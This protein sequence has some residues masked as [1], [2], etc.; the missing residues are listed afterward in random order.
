MGLPPGL[1][2]EDPDL[3]VGR[4]AVVVASGYF[5][6][7]CVDEVD[8]LERV[9]GTTITVNKFDWRISRVLRAADD[10]GTVLLLLTDPT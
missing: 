7:L 8:G 4:P 10:G 6:G 1:A 2:F 5:P 3:T 9:T